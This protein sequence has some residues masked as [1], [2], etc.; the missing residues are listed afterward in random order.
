M[1]WLAT[2]WLLAFSRS[3]E[4]YHNCFPTGSDLSSICIW[5]NW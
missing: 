1:E 5:P 4:P 2:A 3:A